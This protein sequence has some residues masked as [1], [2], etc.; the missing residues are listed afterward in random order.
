MR[1]AAK[2]LSLLSLAVLGCALPASAGL[3][4]RAHMDKFGRESSFKV[5]AT[6]DKAKFVIESSSDPSMP[7]GFAIIVTDGG[8]QLT[9][10]P[11]QKQ[12]YLQLTREEYKKL[13][14]GKASQKQVQIENPK[15][16]ELVVDEDGGMI[17][18]YHTRHYKIKISL[19]DH[20]A[21]QTLNFVV[22]EEFWTA[23]SIPNPAPYLNMLTQQTSG[24]EELD[25]L[26][27]YKKFK[28]LPLKRI[29]ELYAN[30]EFGGRSLVEIT[31]VGQSS[32]PESIFQIPPGYKKIEMPGQA[33]KSS[34]ADSPQ[35]P[36]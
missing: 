20:E 24:I 36:K 3:T 15:L 21:D 6:D 27:D 26:L 30:G 31:E 4:Y 9:L 10:L 11:D 35:E 14:K 8:E 2:S 32:V 13:L 5:W 33:S 12:S 28:G 19:I 18:G 17:A 22:F 1:N 34:E 25:A 29:V 23:P 16:E 7:P